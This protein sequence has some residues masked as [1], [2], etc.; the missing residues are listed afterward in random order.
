VSWALSRAELS[1]LAGAVGLRVVGVA[2]AEPFHALADYLDDHIARG[3]VA[4]M[5]W[6]TP[7]R[8]R[9]S[10]DPRTLLPGV[11]SIVSVAVPFWSGPACPP[12]DGVLR[13]RIARYAW[14][15]DYH[16]TLKRR[17]RA[18]IEALEQ[19]LGRA[20][21]TRALVDTARIVDR[22][23]AA[24]SGTG[25]Y[26]KNAM[27]IVPKHG[28]WVMLGELL[29]DIALPP[30]V[31][32]AQDCGRC[33]ICIQ[34]CPTGAI[35]EP[36]RIDAPRCVS[37]LTIEEH[38]PLPRTLRPL[39]GNFVFGCDICQDVCPYTGAA[40]VVDDPDFAPRSLDNAF[41]SLQLLAEMDVEQFREIYRGTA[42]KRAK[43]AGLARNAAVALG[44]SGDPGAE[45]ILQRMLYH[46][47]TPLAR[48]HAAWGLG[49]LLGSAARGTLARARAMERDDYVREE[50]DATLTALA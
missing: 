42:V 20:L 21:E 9:E 43:R 34:H 24:R 39:L 14:G 32:L 8:A 48:G 37:Y 22:A 35:V 5:D 29:L 19:A 15:D 50:L 2:S 30:D 4:G 38:G 18:R 46:H 45:P 16:V 1:A 41:P 3:H 23:A 40:E 6:F 27:I 11:R 12:D 17:M 33:D 47:D 25:W 26:G 13:G 31:P 7:E 49:Q 28:S 36:Y 10:T 44:N